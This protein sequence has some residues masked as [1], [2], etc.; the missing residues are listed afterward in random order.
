MEPIMPENTAYI[1]TLAALAAG[2][3]VAASIALSASPAQSASLA[4]AL[5]NCGDR[6][7]ILAKLQSAYDEE[8]DAIGLMSDGDV[9]EVVVSDT[10]GTWTILGTYPKRPT[11]IVAAGTAWRSLT[12]LTIGR[13][14]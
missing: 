4:Q 5:R 12:H 11:C 2:V 6:E 13:G 8:P 10:T 3:A 1:Q 7:T 9:L 14:A